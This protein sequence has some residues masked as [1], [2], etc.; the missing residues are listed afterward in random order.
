MKGKI[1][2]IFESIQGEGIYLGKKQ[3]FVR[4]YGCNLACKFCD[5]KPE[6]FIEY[7]PR[8]LFNKVAEYPRDYHSVAFTGGEPLLQKV[9]LKAVLKLTRKAGML[10]YLETN[11]ALPRELKAVINLVDIIAMDL[12]LPSST[13]TGELWDRHRRFLKIALRKEVFLKAVI[14]LST[15]DEDID[16]SLD[17][18]KDSKKRMALVLQPNSY[19]N[20]A[21][22]Q[23]KM[24][25]FRQMCSRENI[26]AWIIPQMQKEL[27][28]K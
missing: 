5:T 23:I 26:A 3:I 7:S 18:I 16:K 2:E 9:F 17:L 24:E 22:L 27:G 8:E 14:S 19:E 12:K 28:L 21:D 25:R 13:Q 1:A 6:S 4:F 15:E 10:N 11:G 20:N